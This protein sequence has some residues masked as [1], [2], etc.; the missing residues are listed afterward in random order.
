ML[1][2]K[3]L[4]KVYKPKKGVP[5]VALDGVDIRFSDTGMVFL[6]G[7]SGSGKSTLLNILGGLDSADSGEILICGASSKQ[8]R[9]KHFDSYRNTY[10]GFIFQEY[11]ILEEFSVGANIAL[12]IELQGKKATDEEINAIL[13]QVD[14]QGYGQRKPSELSGG[15]KQR[16]AIARALVKNPQIIMADEPT[17]ALDSATG[18]QVLDTLRKLSREKLVIVVSHDRDFA[19][20]YADRIIEL[21]DG[22]VIRDET[23]LNEKTA[24]EN[25][26]F[27]GNTV[28]LKAGYHLTEEDRIAIN[29]YMDSLGEEQLQISALRQPTAARKAVPTDSSSIR[30]DSNKP[31]SLIRSR[32]PLKSAVK[33]GAGGLK[34]KKF[35]LVMT[36]FLSCIAFGLFGLSD[37]FGS[38]Q[39]IRACADSIADS[40]VR[41]ASII[42]VKKMH[43]EEDSFY[44]NLG[45]RLSEN[46]LKTFREQTGVSLTGVYQPVSTGPFVLQQYDSSVELSKSNYRIHATEIRGFSEIPESQLENFTGKLLCGRMPDGQKNEILISDYVYETFHKAG[47]SESGDSYRLSARPKEDSETSSSVT[48]DGAAPSFKNIASYEDMIGKS[49]LLGE[50]E[51]TVTGIFDSEVDFSRY[52]RL[53]EEKVNQSDAQNL[54]D[55]ALMNELNGIR[56]YS[57]AQVAVVGEGFVDRMTRQYPDHSVITQAYITL[58][59]E[60]GSFGF[61]PNFAQKFSET[62]PNQVVWFRENRNLQPGEILLALPQSMRENQE[63]WKAAL[64][65]YADL[66]LEFSG[67]YLPDSTQNPFRDRYRVVGVLPISEE[68]EPGAMIVID[69][70]TAEK[71]IDPQD[72]LFLFAAGKMPQKRAEIEKLVTYTLDD[73]GEVRYELQ[74][75]ACYELNIVN[76]VLQVLAKVF[77]WIGIGFA[78]FASIMLANF[79]ATSISYKKQEIGILRAIGARGKDVFSIFFSESFLIAGINFLL[80]SVGVGVLTTLINRLIRAELGI[81]VTVLSFGIRQIALLLLISI[82]VAALASFLPVRRIA[83]KKPIDAI[84]DR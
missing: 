29:R 44:Q 71:L 42:K 8:F 38:Y 75:P 31:F 21:A 40:A 26:S 64:S 46:D 37:T 16:V 33:I 4:T 11:N 66:V 18:R 83:S 51:Y 30:T 9:P 48:A 56:E 45:N 58:Y 72:G 67:R 62:D 23:F 34:Y 24:D 15:Q 77:F 69:D 81:L 27:S 13:E 43:F 65:K 39:H 54:V 61:S 49:L 41:Y 73:K 32:L 80:S 59:Q 78:V 57:L 22:R 53:I 79:I 47:Y 84:R 74:N 19:R 12:A 50:T 5:V 25:L 1:E 35:R 60:D 63:Q 36:I 17:G 6:L 76:S 82:A 20:Q 14:L 28:T 68:F 70:Q 7:K 3:K 10:I 2:A 55:F 52:D